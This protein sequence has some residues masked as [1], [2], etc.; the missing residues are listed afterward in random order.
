MLAIDAMRSPRARHWI[1]FQLVFSTCAPAATL[2]VGPGQ[3]YA[4]PCGALAAASAGD[5]IQ[6]DASGDYSGDVCGWATNGLTIVGVDGRPIIDAAGESMDGRATWVISG[7]NTTVE[8]IEFS[9]A[10]GPS[11]NGAAIWLRGTNLTVRKCYIH[12]N[13]DGILTGENLSSQVVIENTEFANNGYGDGQSHNIYIGHVAKFTMRFCYSHDAISGHLVKSRAVENFILYNRLTGE[14]GTSSFELDLSNGGLA[15]VIGNVIEQGPNSE[16]ATI[17]AYGLEGMT[18]PNSN[19]YFVNNTVVNNRWNGIFIRVGDGAAPILAQNNIF[20]GPGLLTDQVHARMSHNLRGSALFVDA[21]NYDYRLQ[22]SSVAR[23]F[24]ADPE[25]GNGYSL[26]PIYQYVHPTCFE[27]RATSGRTID[28]GAFEYHGGGGADA[29]CASKATLSNIILSSSNVGGGERVNGTLRLTGPAPAGGI[30]LALSSSDPSVAAVPASVTIPQDSV[31]GSFEIVTTNVTSA[32]SVTISAEDKTVT[33][34]AALRI[35]PATPAI[36]S[37]TLAR[38]AVVGGGAI[39]ATVKLR[40][41][42]SANETIITLMSFP[43]EIAL[44]PPRVT[45]PAG[46]STAT[47]TIKTA[48]VGETT[49]AMIGAA[50]GG[51]TKT[52]HLTVSPRGR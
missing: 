19:L 33:K 26:K 9:G 49:R 24:G 11:Q 45:V 46:S 1:C 43:P 23:N 47:F 17:M 4:K 22:R 36:A 31:S 52:V 15:Y 44:V 41:P 8:N 50:Y 13:E 5:T 12:G 18:N 35:G 7:N 2:R 14:S 6:I 28:A 37:L 27:T 32:N 20:V 51:V 21:S 16:N 40:N 34:S 30:A 3:Q 42:S 25:M 48:T 38:E 39:T 29:S 10:K